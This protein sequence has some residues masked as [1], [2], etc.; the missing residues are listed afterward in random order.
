MKW[1]HTNSAHD[2]STRTRDANNSYTLL[3]GPKQ[4]VKLI[5]L[6]LDKPI[7][8][9]LEFNL[10]LYNTRSQRLPFVSIFKWVYR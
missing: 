7:L 2:N 6:A 4:I 5:R 8:V 3:S 9:I 1:L 10:A